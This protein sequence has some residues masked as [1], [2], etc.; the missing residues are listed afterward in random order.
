MVTRSNIIEQMGGL[1]P[2]SVICNSVLTEKGYSLGR[3]SRAI[4]NEPLA[5]WRARVRHHFIENLE[6]SPLVLDSK[7]DCFIASIHL[8]AGEAVYPEEELQLI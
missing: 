3:A 5:I 7:I 6:E 4:E 2:N 8:W 1:P